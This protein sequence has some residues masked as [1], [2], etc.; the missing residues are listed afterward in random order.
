MPVFFL[1]LFLHLPSL[2]DPT[3]IFL[4]PLCFPVSVKQSRV[5]GAELLGPSENPHVHRGKLLLMRRDF[6][7]T[8]QVSCWRKGAE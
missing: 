2:S 4:C 7:T 5:V 6:L 3:A 8:M 1:H